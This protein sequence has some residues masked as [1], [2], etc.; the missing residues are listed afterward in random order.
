MTSEDD[1]RDEAGDT[2]EQSSATNTSAIPRLCGRIVRV[3]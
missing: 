3:H 1:E 2:D